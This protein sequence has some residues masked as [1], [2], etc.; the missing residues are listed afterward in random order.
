MYM[1]C[2]QVELDR[3]GNIPATKFPPLPNLP[4]EKIPVSKF[5][6]VED[7]PPP[8]RPKRTAAAAGRKA[9]ATG[10]GSE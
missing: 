2:L 1:L 8:Q 6:Y 7:L 9:I 10:S 5:V 4:K 3:M